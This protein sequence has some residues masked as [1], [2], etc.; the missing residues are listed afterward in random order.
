MKTIYIASH[1]ES[2]KF[3]QTLAKDLEVYGYK[4]D[5]DWTQHKSL[6][7]LAANNPAIAKATSAHD[8]LGAMTCDVF[9]LLA[10]GES[11]GAHTEFGIALAARLLTGRPKDIVVYYT[12]QNESIFYKAPGVILI[13]DDKDALFRVLRILNL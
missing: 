4:F 8:I 9:L 2:Y 10:D 5:F 13:Q 7:A 6:E 1:F 12:K 11:R 3:V